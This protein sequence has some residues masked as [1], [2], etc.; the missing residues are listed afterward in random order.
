M[1]GLGSLKSETRAV[2]SSRV[3]ITVRLRAGRRNVR[4][5]IMS[6]S[7]KRILFFG[8]VTSTMRFSILSVLNLKMF[9]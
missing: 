5:S 6:S 2:C 8:K 7:E 1:A 3:K 4:A 9:R